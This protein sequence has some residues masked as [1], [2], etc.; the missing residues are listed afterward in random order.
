MLVNSLSELKDV[1]RTTITNAGALKYPLS[2]KIEPFKPVQSKSQRGLYQAITRRMADYT[3]Y[4]HGEM[5]LNLQKQFLGTEDLDFKWRGKWVKKERVIGTANL[6][7]EDYSKFLESV[8][9]VAA[10]MDI[11]P[12]GDEE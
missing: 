8:L 2:V 7:K 9:Q 6:E 11:F 3:G 10:E 12:I 4:A 1:L 5:K